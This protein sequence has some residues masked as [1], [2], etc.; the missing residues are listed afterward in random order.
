ML[1]MRKRV[2]RLLVDAPPAPGSIIGM[3]PLESAV[4]ERGDVELVRRLLDEGADPNRYG[5]SGT[6]PLHY[7]NDLDIVKLLLDKGANTEL[8]DHDRETPR[9]SQNHVG[10][11]CQP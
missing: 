8:Q 7:T 10:A 1:R 11:R 6:T 9:Q 3:T 4:M 5:A 2:K